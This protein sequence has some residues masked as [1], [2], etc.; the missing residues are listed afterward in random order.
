MTLHDSLRGT[1]YAYVSKFGDKAEDIYFESTEELCEALGYILHNIKRIDAEIPDDQYAA[2]S[3]IFP[4]YPIQNGLTTGGNKM[5]RAPQ[6]RIYFNTIR[7]MPAKL[8]GRLQNDNQMRI[9]GSL[10]VEACFFIGFVPWYP[11]QNKNQIQMAVSSV[12]PKSSEQQAFM[13]G[14]NL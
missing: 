8:R 14:Y 3:A 13:Q 7:N 1:A 10:F 9:T 6:Y 12:F 5:K 11:T 2:L 4:N